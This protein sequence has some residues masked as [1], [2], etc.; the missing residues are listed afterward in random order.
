MTTTTLTNYA[1]AYAVGRQHVHFDCRAST[2]TT[3]LMSDRDAQG[4]WR[5]IRA[6]SIIKRENGILDFAWLGLDGDIVQCMA[7]DSAGNK[8]EFVSYTYSVAA[9][10][11]ADVVYYVN[12][13]TGND[14]TGDGSSGLPW[15]TPGK[16][17]TEM[18]SALGGTESGVIF[19][20]GSNTYV[21]T[22][23]LWGWW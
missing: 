20:S 7:V 11:A 10:T 4:Y 12:S 9:N 21:I 6:G 13:A 8:G 23:S 22:G 18:A 3:G 19:I 16:A 1:S 15:A 2:P 14:S 17:A 5:V